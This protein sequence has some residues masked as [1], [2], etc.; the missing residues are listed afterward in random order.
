LPAFRAVLER[1]D[2]EGVDAILCLGDTVGYGPQPSECIDLMMERNIP[3]VMGNHDACVVGKLTE[4]FFSEP[5]RSLLRWTRDTLRPDQI[6][7]LEGLPMTMDNGQWT[8]D[9]ELDESF[10]A[11]HASPIHPERW[12]WL[13]SA[14][15]CR[16]VLAEVYYKFVFVG[17]THVPALV[18]SELGVFGLEQGYKFLINPGSIGQGRDHDR[19]ASFGILDFEAFTYQNIR[20]HYDVSP[21]KASFDKLGYSNTQVKRLMN[22]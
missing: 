6:A 12:R 17:H 13:D 8:L 4:N 1:I 3:S 16:E 2:Q 22:V 7:W 9:I 19:R 18:P 11:A 20:L 10:I 14:I 5:N 15:T 21:L